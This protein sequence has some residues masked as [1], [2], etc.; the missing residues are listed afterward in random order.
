MID[1]SG[2]WAGHDFNTWT[3]CS[4][5]KL[6]V[7]EDL[8]AGAPSCWKACPGSYMCGRPT[9]S[10][11]WYSREST[12]PSHRTSTREPSPL[13]AP[14]I[15]MLD[16]NLTDVLKYFAFKRSPIRR[17]TYD[18]RF[19]CS[20]NLH[21][22]EKMTFSHLSTGQFSLFLHHWNRMLRWRKDKNGFRTATR[23][24]NPYRH[25]VRF[26]VLMD[27]TSVRFDSCRT[28]LA[29]HI[30]F[31]WEIRTTLSPIACSKCVVFRFFLC[32]LL[33]QSPWTFWWCIA[34]ISD[35]YSG[36]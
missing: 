22:S 2:L 9:L 1:R 19:G 6:V 7:D 10:T 34:P 29:V 11:R 36:T 3:P 27:T 4:S 31:A 25:K 8:W 12:F 32:Q 35:R 5:K 18:R 24:N 30:A 33:F 28:R 16:G 14:Q 17:R 20:S 23:P 13:I 21:S 15:M 26:I